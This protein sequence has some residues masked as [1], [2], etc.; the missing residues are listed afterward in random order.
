MLAFEWESQLSALIFPLGDP[1]PPICMFV[2]S[3]V[4]AF[5]SSFMFRQEEIELQV[6]WDMY[7]HASLVEVN[8]LRIFAELLNVEHGTFQAEER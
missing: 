1:W 4:E 7:D 3:K 6:R 5:Y 8:K 2:V